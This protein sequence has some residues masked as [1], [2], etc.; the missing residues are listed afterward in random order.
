MKKKSTAKTPEVQQPAQSPLSAMDRLLKIEKGLDAAT[1]QLQQLARLSQDTAMRLASS[2][3]SF[4]SIA[5]LIK[6]L[7]EELIEAKLI[8][9]VQ[10]TDRI[11]KN[12]EEDEAEKVTKMI[13]QGFIRPASEVSESSLIAVSQ[14]QIISDNGTTKEKKLTGYRIVEMTSPHNSPEL[15]KDIIGKKV[16][17]T[18]IVARDGDG[19]KTSVIDLTVLAIYEINTAPKGETSTK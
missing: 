12:N 5:K 17:D 10:V 7:A 11:A 15:K 8:T 14:K 6:A 4:S 18:I 9:D 19:P 3:Q 1:F 2:E 13:E 16:G